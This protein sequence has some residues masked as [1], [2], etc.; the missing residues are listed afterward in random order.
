MGRR[1][2]RRPA[3]RTERRTSRVDPPRATRGLFD[4]RAPACVPARPQR[5]TTQ[6]R[7][8]QRGLLRRSAIPSIAMTLQFCHVIARQAPRERV[9]LQTETAADRSL[10][11]VQGQVA[12]AWRDCACFV[13][14]RPAPE[15]RASCP[16]GRSVGLHTAERARTLRRYLR[17]CQRCGSREL[18]RSRRRTWERVLGWTGLKPYRC[19][20]CDLRCY[21][22]QSR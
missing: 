10:E 15:W 8:E 18:T 6:D 1:A 13:R 7:A 22:F 21:R 20:A 9:R 14:S 12:S 3:L 5:G 16:A 2:G 11:G 17:P 19:Q 4:G